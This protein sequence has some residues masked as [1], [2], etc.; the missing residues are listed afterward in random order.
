MV[1]PIYLLAALLV[2]PA[3][4]AEPI[5][6]CVDGAGKVQFTDGP[7]AAGC[8]AE[9]VDLSHARLSGPRPS[10]AAASSR[11]SVQA[12]ARAMELDRLRRHGKLPGGS[13][14]RPGLAS[15]RSAVADIDR[16]LDALDTK[17]RHLRET[18]GNSRHSIRQRFNREDLARID[19]QRAA[20]HRERSRRL[21]EADR[22][23][24]DQARKAQSGSRLLTQPE[25]DTRI[26]A[27]GGM[28]R[29]T[30]DPPPPQSAP[31]RPGI[32]PAYRPADARHWD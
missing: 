26:R 30:V 1:R 8:R 4:A 5:T 25:V 31:G 17:E 11:Y 24:L 23:R 21:K 15:D 10:R 3:I 28:P 16:Q 2:A 13:A 29:I 14:S 32:H 9:V 19:E 7:C 27:Q 12:Q 20:L 22:R 6:K 18:F